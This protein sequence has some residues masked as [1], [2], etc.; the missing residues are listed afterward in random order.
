MQADETTVPVIATPPGYNSTDVQ[1]HTTAS[2]SSRLQVIPQRLARN[3][4]EG[5]NVLTLK[6][7]LKM[8]GGSE[9]KTSPPGSWKAAV[10]FT[11]LS[12]AANPQSGQ[13]EGSCTFHITPTIFTVRQLKGSCT[14][15][16]TP[17]IFTVR[18]LE[19]SCTFHIT[20]TIFTVRQ[21]EG[22]C[23]FH[24]TPTIFTSQH[25]AGSDLR[26]EVVVMTSGSVNNTQSHKRESIPPVTPL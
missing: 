1:A 2:Y 13:L 8:L 16:I 6:E 4:E 11:S 26:S 18:Q 10:W 21:L 22:S 17:T 19:G 12:H 15:H 20:P 24:I 7:N 5:I 23:T 3:R 25:R 9:A 14:F